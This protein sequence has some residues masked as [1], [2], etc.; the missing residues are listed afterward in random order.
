[1]YMYECIYRIHVCV[2]VCVR[3]RARAGVVCPSV[4]VRLY[5]RLCLEECTDALVRTRTSAAPSAFVCS[6]TL[7]HARTCGCT[8]TCGCRWLG[9]DGRASVYL[10]NV[11]I[12]DDVYIPIIYL[13]CTYM[14]ACMHACVSV[15][16]RCAHRHRYV[17]VLRQIPRVSM[18]ARVSLAIRSAK[19]ICAWTSVYI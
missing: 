9:I 17:C 3:V 13:L 5:R 11:Y 15:W 16:T 6:H 19:Y 4:R 14:H 10:Y 12:H 7:V 8:N 2:N 1:M 18:G